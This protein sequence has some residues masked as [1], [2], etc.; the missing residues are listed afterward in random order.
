MDKQKW[1]ALAKKIDGISD[2]TG[3]VFCWLVIPLTVLICYEVFTRR[4]LGA[5]TIWTFELSNFLYGAHFML[6]SAYGLLRKSHVCIDLFVM[7]GS[8]RT[9]QILDLTCYFVLFFPFIIMVLYHG[10]DFAKD[11]WA[12]W[13]TS[14]STWAPPLYPIKT[15]IPVTAFLLLIQGISEVIKKVIFLKTGEEL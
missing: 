15:V 6:V 9:A 10:V 8:K 3:R 2:W 14:W 11:S 7:R 5:P 4:V 13:E 1:L 12:N